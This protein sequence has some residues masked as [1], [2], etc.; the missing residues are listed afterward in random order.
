VRTTR[1]QNPMALLF[2]GQKVDIGH[3]AKKILIKNPE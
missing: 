2:P 1:L 3:L